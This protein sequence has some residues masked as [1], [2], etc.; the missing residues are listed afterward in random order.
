MARALV[1]LLMATSVVAALLLL[2]GSGGEARPAAA[3]PHGDIAPSERPA[4]TLVFVT[5]SGRLV[6]IDV[7]SGRRVTRRVPAI[8]S[9]G[10]EM[11]VTGGHVV[12]AGVRNDHTVVFS[13]P[14]TLERRPTLLGRAHAFA[15]SATEG[16]VWLVGT[17]CHRPM[18]AGY[19]EV[20]VHGSTIRVSRVRVPGA[21]L[22]AATPAGLVVQRGRAGLGIW[23]PATRATRTLG[24]DGVSDAHG[25]RLTGCARSCSTPAIVDTET[26]RTVVARWSGR[27]RLEDGRLLSGAALVAVER[28]AVRAGSR[29]PHPGL[30]ARRAARRGAA[31]PGAAP[32]DRLHGRL[33]RA[34]AAARRPR[35]RRARR[36]SRSRWQSMRDRARRHPARAAAQARRR[37]GRSG[38]AGSC[39]PR[40]PPGS[41]VHAR[42][43]GGHAGGPLSAAR[44]S[45]SGTGGM[46]CRSS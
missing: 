1:L 4:G 6:A 37:A 32:G 7:A 34:R 30:P 13:V 14:M 2:P 39:C 42:L 15:P 44:E 12:F 22:A 16:R 35:P 9:C 24:L 20:T 45:P 46:C 5:G 11:H 31:V 29:Q 41:R 19:R 18:M 26:G 10:P 27:G 38:P 17:D 40:P 33:S 8:A 28:L 25:E 36:T 23:D 43:A 3:S 21:W